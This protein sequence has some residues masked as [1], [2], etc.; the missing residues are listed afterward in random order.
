MKKILRSKLSL[1]ICLLLLILS[2]ATVGIVKTIKHDPVVTAST[3][4]NILNTLDVQKPIQV[5]STAKIGSMG[6]L[7]IHSPIL[8]A[9]CDSTSQ[10][11]NFEKIFTYIT[12]YV[13]DL[14]YAAIDLEGSL[15]GSR[16]SGYPLFRCPDNMIDSAKASG[17]KL[18]LT[19]NNHSNDAGEKG[20]FRTI[21]ILRQKNV[22]FIGTR[23]NVS[24]K[25][26][27]IQDINGIRVAMVNYTYGTI[28][29]NGIA[30]VNGLSL[31][32]ETSPL[33]NVFDYNRLDKFYSEQ[34]KL[35][36]RI[37]KDNAHAIVYF[38]HWGSEYQ[39]EENNFQR[40]IA[41]KL[42][43]LGVDVIV[44]GHPHVI[45]PIDIIHS[46][47][48]NKDTVCIY[49]LGNAVSNQRKSLMDLKTGHTE[50]GV[51]FSFTFT[52][53]SD[54]SVMLTS[55]DVMPTWVN[56][57]VEQEKHTYQII[58]LD[59]QK[60]WATQFNMSSQS[61]EMAQKSYDRTMDIV[62]Q[63]LTKAKDIINKNVI[64]THPNLHE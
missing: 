38:M 21:E 37:R 11:Y 2:F 4:D 42:S 47:L 45:Q 50:D 36:E 28:N 13:K 63:G 39:T 62:S 5:I 22:D 23:G 14:D 53:Y 7:L 61:C 41:K 17:F 18:F 49:S 35:L 8:R 33:I 1:I 10:S 27:I 60:D 57:Y 20:F 31:S 19:A 54:D 51:L 40:S 29:D 56:L 32:K 34:E 9:F 58:P 44:G 55:V 3:Q 43:D 16:F 15:A 48:S 64:D 26:Y 52:K 24:D 46:D 59:K 25:N 30:S 12:P 6:D